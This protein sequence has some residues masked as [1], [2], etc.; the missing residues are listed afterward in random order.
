MVYELKSNSA[1]AKIDTIG[2]ELISFQDVFGVQ[3][4]W[5]KDEKYW[6][7]CSPVL[8]PIVGGL[9]NDKTIIEGKEYKIPKHGFCRTADFK[10]MFKGED[11]LILNYCFN[12]ETLAV[13]PYKFSLTLTYSLI[14][15][16]LEI[17]YTV[18]NLDDKP[19]DYCLGAH[20]GFNV[21]IGEEG[22][23]EDYCIEFNKKETVLS[24]VF[25]VQNLEV[26]VNNRIDL[27]GDDN[28]IMLKHSL[29]D[30]DAIIFD[31]LNSDSIKLYSIKTGRGV[32]VDF[33]GFDSI[34]FWTPT[35][36][37]AP[38]LCVEPW[39]GMAVRSDE[40][41]QFA[42]KLGVQHLEINQQKKH[43]LLITPM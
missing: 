28:K 39:N 11:K 35:G 36:M 15:G 19:M 43:T 37:S 20:P 24:P 10:V 31:E 34:A 6:N 27:F 12:E 7:K 23:F 3:Y 26:N 22:N 25:D 8:F 29:F 17:L 32:Q 21:P 9:R 1:I 4:M 13:Y 40:D 42:N 5:Q 38:F 14:D 16:N 33:T 2:A 30:N 18:L 41:D